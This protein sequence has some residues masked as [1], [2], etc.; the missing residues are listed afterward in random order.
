MTMFD[1]PTAAAITLKTSLL[2]V[3]VALL[4]VL[5]ARRSAAWRHFLWTSALALS[6]LMPIAVVYLPATVQLTLPWTLAEPWVRDE[7]LPAAAAR[8]TDAALRAPAPQSNLPS[9]AERGRPAAWPTAWVIWLVGVVG[10]CLRILLAHVGLMRWRRAASG[11]LSP[12]W[13]ATLHRVIREAPLR[14]PLRVLETDRT[15]SACT[16]GFLRP[17][18]LLPAAGNAWPE[19]QRRFAL[20]HELAHVRRFDY[21]TTQ[22]AGLACALHW[23]N[24]LVWFA[25]ARAGRLQ[26]QACDDVVLSSGGTASDYAGFLVGIAGGPGRRSLACPAAVGMVQRSQLHGRVTAILDA[27]R[28]RL[29]VSGLA[30]LAAVVPLAGLMFLLATVTAVSSVAAVGAPAV[31]AGIPLTASFREVELRNGGR[32]TLVHGPTQRVALLKGDP[33]QSLIAVDADGRLV[34]DHCKAAD[35]AHV[36]DFELEVTTPSLAGIA[37]SEG[38]IVQ[39]RDGFPHQSQVR[40]A[41]SN[42]GMVDVRT[43]PVSNV[44]ASVYSGG[45]IFAKPGSSLMASVEQGGNVTY[46]GD[47]FVHE[48]IQFGGVVQ[49][50]AAADFTKSLA[51]LD[52]AL[53]PPP[54]VP[55]VPPVAAI[56]PIQPE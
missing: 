50:G 48:S 42:G 20:L 11:E 7:A 30:L 8:G 31:Q 27:S 45:R 43:L 5:M 38:G 29:P 26:E 3:A 35:C 54:P 9:M 49:Q 19:P 22:V 4:G 51:D 47:P 23:F 25:A 15:G 44:T 10:V 14:R 32:V 1:L 46:W 2:F 53:R 28:A 21:L 24:P 52:P 6:L 33:E 39:A 18:I 40:L 55:P 56:P 34:I 17:V 41:V 36:H 12:A 13:S 16:W 37:V